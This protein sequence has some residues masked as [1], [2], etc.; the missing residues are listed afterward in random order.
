M[1]EVVLNFTDSVDDGAPSVP[2]VTLSG[3]QG[4]TTTYYA[5]TV[6]S[7][8]FRVQAGNITTT[9][10][11]GITTIQPDQT[12]GLTVVTPIDVI[13]PTNNTSVT[14]TVDG[15]AIAVG[16]PTYDYSLTVSTPSAN[17]SLP[18]WDS[19]NVFTGVTGQVIES[20]IFVQSNP[21]YKVDTA[22]LTGSLPTNVTIGEATV[23]G[24]GA[25]VP[26]SV[27]ITDANQT[28]N[29][30]LAASVSQEPYLLTVNLSETLPLAHL[31]Q[32][33]FTQ[34]F[35]PDD[36]GT[37]H[38]F[39]QVSI[40]P[41]EG[42]RGFVNAGSA[43]FPTVTGLNFNNPLISDGAI[44]FE[45]TADIPDPSDGDLS[46][47]ANIEAGIPPT[48]QATT[49]SIRAL[50]AGIS[51]AGGNAVFEVVSNG[52]FNLSI[53]LSGSGVDAALS[54]ANDDTGSFSISTTTGLLVLTGGY[55]P[56]NGIGGTTLVDLEVGQEPFYLNPA[57]STGLSASYFVPGPGYELIVH[58]RNPDGSDGAEL[59][60]A[61]VLQSDT[62]G[63]RSYTVPNA[64]TANDPTLLNITTAKA[65][66][67]ILQITNGSNHKRHKCKTHC[68]WSNARSGNSQRCKP[69]RRFSA[70]CCFQR[71]A[72]Q[73]RIFSG[74]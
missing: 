33:S 53:Q 71:G 13:F 28:G 4:S 52:L 41:N 61:S 18:D 40:T 8:G 66:L 16:V 65:Q 29:L 10:T 20:N 48:I 25:V 54:G 46:Y 39:G 23:Q 58:S 63:G 34:R 73:C 32:T 37:T 72:F 27:T 38:S 69:T 11:S 24:D 42:E 31:T 21:G 26:I 9:D 35:G 36:Y 19:P 60:R 1:I 5:I 51:S 6:P 67:G 49:A 50:T 59:D 55:S 17:V 57:G 56:T 12:R 47:T 70:D 64:W 3:V 30:V 74:S 2:S 68:K 44:T 14:L 43:T 45:L 7:A 15:D 22:A 62:Y